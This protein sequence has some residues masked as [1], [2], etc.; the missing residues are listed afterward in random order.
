MNNCRPYG[1]PLKSI[2]Q[3]K[4]F[5]SDSWY[6][7]LWPRLFSDIFLFCYTG[8]RV[9]VVHPTLFSTAM[10]AARLVARTPSWNFSRVAITNR[11]LTRTM[12]EYQASTDTRRSTT[13]GSE[14]LRSTLVQ[15]VNCACQARTVSQRTVP[16]QTSGSICGP[17]M[18]TPTATTRCLV[19][20]H[21]V[22][23]VLLVFVARTTPCGLCIV[24]HAYVINNYLACNKAYMRI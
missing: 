17:V 1:K 23:S 9:M 2:K 10:M 21:R 13:M 11:S 5:C 6:S 8:S 20:S 15:L 14:R 18:I 12:A 3:L 7:V 4:S 22:G 19:E 24:K 16:D